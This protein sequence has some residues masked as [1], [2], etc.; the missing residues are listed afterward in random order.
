MPESPVPEKNSATPG[1]R[2]TREKKSTEKSAEK[3]L[4]KKVLVVVFNVWNALLGDFQGGSSCQQLV[5]IMHG[6]SH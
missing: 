2:G 3:K 1:S 5:I 6:V 4:E